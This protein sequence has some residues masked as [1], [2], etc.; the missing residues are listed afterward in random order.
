MRGLTVLT[1]LA[2]IHSLQGNLTEEKPKKRHTSDDMINDK[3]DRYL[4]L[5][6]RKKHSIE[7]FL[8]DNYS[9]FNHSDYTPEVYFSLH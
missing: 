8:K 3:I 5:L 6:Q 4:E 9:D 7:K 1:L 2:L